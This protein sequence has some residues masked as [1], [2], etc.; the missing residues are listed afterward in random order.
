MAHNPPSDARFAFLRDPDLYDLVVRIAMK[1]VR[2]AVF[3]EDI[4]QG[5]YVVAMVLVRE[6]KG[7]RPGTERG[8]MCRVTRNHTYE[9]LRAR[10]SEEPPLDTDETPD[11][12][13]DDQPTLLADQMQ[14]ER[15]L[16]AAEQV[17]ATHPKQAAEVLAGD[18]RSE[19]RAKQDGAKDAATRKRRQRARAFLQTAMGLAVGAAL[20]LLLLR[21]PIAPRPGLPPGSY[22]TLADA[23][24]D[25]A[26][27]SCDASEWVTCLEDFEQ[28][29]RLDAARLGPAE[30]ARRD[31]AILAIRRDA[32]TACKRER[33]LECLEGLDT[34]RRFDRAGESDPAVMRARTEAQ[35]RIGESGRGVAHPAPP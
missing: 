22:S 18:A 21:G 25:L 19:E 30:Q 33:F 1:M 28:V 26:R 20:V 35:Q 27:K 34:A 9:A 8:W 29:E 31:E 16:A 3:A 11:I 13:V 4:R 2:D 17:A 15:R 14:V 24:L 5:A 6:G 10:K 32:L 23:A 7:P 12:P